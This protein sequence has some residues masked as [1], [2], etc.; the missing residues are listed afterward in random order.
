MFFAEQS[1]CQTKL[2]LASGFLSPSLPSFSQV[3]SSGPNSPAC[4]ISF[5][6]PVRWSRGDKQK[7]HFPYTGW[8]QGCPKD[9]E[10]CS[11]FRIWVWLAPISCASGKAPTCFS[12]YYGKN[13]SSKKGKKS[14]KTAIS[15][16]LPSSAP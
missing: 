13:N 2:G 14:Y 9:L 16:S 15:L 1:V 6:A 10:K 7:Y 8:M 11:R 12:S 4:A 3:S 5:S